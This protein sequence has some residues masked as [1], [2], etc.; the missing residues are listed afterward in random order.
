MK[1]LQ[2]IYRNQLLL[3]SAAAQLASA[4]G[5]TLFNETIDFVGKEEID[6]LSADAAVAC[7]S[8]SGTAWLF[9]RVLYQTITLVPILL[10]TPLMAMFA[11]RSDHIPRPEHEPQLFRI[12]TL[13]IV[14]GGVT[15]LLFLG[16]T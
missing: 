6:K 1:A 3:M 14:L 11:K 16:R 10:L 7:R 5:Q 2:R 15:L 9:V 12:V 8:I 4:A 13:A